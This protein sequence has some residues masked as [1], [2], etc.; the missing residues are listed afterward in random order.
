MML[1][2]RSMPERG[3][4][5]SALACFSWSR[6]WSCGSSAVKFTFTP[7]FLEHS[8]GCCVFDNEL[9]SIQLGS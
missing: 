2:N 3:I 9:M 7:G 5:Y 8:G 1:I 4:W 6:S